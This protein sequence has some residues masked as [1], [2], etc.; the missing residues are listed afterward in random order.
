[1]LELSVLQVLVAARWPKRSIIVALGVLILP[2]A[3]TDNEY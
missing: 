1:M 2:H 3:A